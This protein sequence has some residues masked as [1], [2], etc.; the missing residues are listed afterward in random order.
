MSKANKI[1]LIVAIALITTIGLFIANAFF[2]NPIM[3]TIAKKSAQT[4]IAEQFDEEDLEVETVFYN[5]KDGYYH[6]NIKSMT[7]V[8]THFTVFLKGKK[9]IDHSYEE[10]VVSGW[11]TYERID[12]KY[13]ELVE[14]VF[15]ADDFP[16]ISEID[17]GTIE[18]YEKSSA[19][20]AYDEVDYGISLDELELDKE[21]DVKQLAET[22]GHIIYYAQDEEITFAK[23]SEFVLLIKDKL[24][25]AN[26]PFF[27]LDFVL[28]KPRDEAGAI[29]DDSESIHIVNFLFD[30]IYEEGL[31]ERIEQAHQALMDYYES[32]DARQKD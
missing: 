12:A 8:D 3:N 18:L 28:E 32:E 30:D 26:L 7:S 13:R 1:I 2:G 22:A 24:T 31:E 16:L 11:N 17:F 5:F 9:V 27:A 14:E 19:P 15:S 20:V 29:V 6:A 4:Y 21:Y 10:D 25:E 23:A